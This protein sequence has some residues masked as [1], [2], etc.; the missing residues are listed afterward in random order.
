VGA[1]T[2]QVALGLSDGRYLVGDLGFTTSYLAASADESAVEG[3]IA[4]TPIGQ[5][6]AT[7]ADARFAR[8]KSIKEGE[9]PSVL[10]DRA[11]SAQGEPRRAI[12]HA[13]SAHRA[14]RRLHQP[15]QRE[16]EGGQR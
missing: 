15:G 8:A 5:R 1:K 16:R 7:L 10:L 9:G 2:T 3:V 4:T 11:E 14:E 6:R 12:E 13:N